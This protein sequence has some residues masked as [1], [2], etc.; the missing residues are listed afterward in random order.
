VS[1]AFG[2]QPLL[3]VKGPQRITVELAVPGRHWEVA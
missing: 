2:Y 1:E 3:S